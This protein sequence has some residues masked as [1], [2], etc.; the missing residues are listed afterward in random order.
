MQSVAQIV[1]TDKARCRDCYRCVRACPVKAIGV[2]EG[3]AFVVANRCISCGTCIR[4]CP[5]GAKAFRN[6]LEKAIRLLEGEDPVAAS[7]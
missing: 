3:Q 1:F 6:D 2:R 7:R 5:Q 4:E